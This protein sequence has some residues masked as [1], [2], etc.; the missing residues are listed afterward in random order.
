MKEFIMLL[1]ISKV[2]FNGIH[3]TLTHFGPS[4]LLFIE[5]LSFFGGYF[6]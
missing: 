5:K 4:L 1:F 2:P 3:E 6:V